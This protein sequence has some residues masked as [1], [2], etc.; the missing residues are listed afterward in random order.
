MGRDFYMFDVDLYCYKGNKGNLKIEDVSDL[1]ICSDTFMPQL[2]EIRRGLKTAKMGSVS[3]SQPTLW[4]TM[5]SGRKTKT[6]LRPG[7]DVDQL[8]PNSQAVP[9]PGTINEYALFSADGLKSTSKA[10]LA[11][12]E[13]N[14]TQ[15]LG[16]EKV[17][18][19]FSCRFPPTNRSI[20]PLT[21]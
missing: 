5:S 16:L 13:G 12:E 18:H 10:R 2:K 21:H 14:G 9:I 20:D 3:H 19:H 1:S 4:M 15:V 6:F 7:Q 17:N 8:K 11:L